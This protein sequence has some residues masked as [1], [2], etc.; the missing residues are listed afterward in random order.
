M[1]DEIQALRAG[2]HEAVGSEKELLLARIQQAEPVYTFAA[3]SCFV[4]VLPLPFYTDGLLVR[5]LKGAFRQS[6]LWYVV[7]PAAVYVLDGQAQSLADID[8]AYPPEKDERYGLF[9]L[10]FSKGSLPDHFGFT[11]QKSA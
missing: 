7:F 11:A 8:A 5:V 9:Y 1:E 2:W 4:D 10:V 6:P 3:D